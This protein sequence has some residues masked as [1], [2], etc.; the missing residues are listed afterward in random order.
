MLPLFWV[1]V[2]LIIISISWAAVIRA[3]GDTRSMMLIGLGSQLVVAMPVSWLLGVV[4]GYGLAGVV[5]G[6]T[7]GWLVRTLLS[8]WRLSRVAALHPPEVGKRRA[9]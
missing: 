6:M 1:M 4:A 7:S 2:P 3:V 8:R 5:A 9:A